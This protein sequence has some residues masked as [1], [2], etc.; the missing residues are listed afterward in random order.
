VERVALHV[1]ARH[2]GVEEAQVEAA[3]VADQDRPFAAIGLEGLAHATEDVGQRCFFTH[4]HA[5]R[6]IELD[7]GEFQG[8]GFDVRAFERLDAEE[9]G[10]LRVHKPFSS[11]AMVVAAISSRA[12]VAELKPPVSTSTTTGR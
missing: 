11:M 4:R 5:Q 1:Q 10:V 3:V 2:R 7:P 8:G 9:V 6:V 12:S